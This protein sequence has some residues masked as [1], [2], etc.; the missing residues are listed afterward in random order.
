MSMREL[1][2]GPGIDPPDPTVVVDDLE[3]LA[4]AAHE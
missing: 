4:L 1:A 3:S 2:A